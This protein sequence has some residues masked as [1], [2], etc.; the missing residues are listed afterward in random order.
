MKLSMNPTR[1]ALLAA[2]ALALVAA[3][4]APA[5]PKPVIKLAENASN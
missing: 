4:C 5:K 2:A 3:A 1:R